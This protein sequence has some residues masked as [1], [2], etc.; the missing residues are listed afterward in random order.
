MFDVFIHPGWLL[1]ETGLRCGQ[2]RRIGLAACS[3]CECVQAHHLYSQPESR[4][5]IEKF[6]AGG[7]QASAS[8]VFTDYLLLLEYRSGSGRRAACFRFAA[9][10]PSS[11]LCSG[12]A[13]RGLH[14]FDAYNCKG[15][16]MPL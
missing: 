6:R 7:E 5:V 1:R 16:P 9:F 15:D 2:P 8:F 14:E 11:A 10:S 3:S 4:K 13:V 12:T